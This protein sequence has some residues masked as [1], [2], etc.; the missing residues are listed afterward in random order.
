M[1][2]TVFDANGIEDDKQVAVL[3]T[4][5]GSSPYALLSSLIAPRKP[6]EKS[7]AELTETLC[8]HF[9]PK[10]LVIAKR[11]HLHRRNQASG[12]NISEYVG[13]ICGRAE[14]TGDALQIWQLLG[15]SLMRSF[16]LWTSTREHTEEIVD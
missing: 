4:A 2:P 3:L 12:E 16:H 8:C 13:L 11:F 1:C 9:D 7:F 10:P 6:R 15:A 14:M 5:I